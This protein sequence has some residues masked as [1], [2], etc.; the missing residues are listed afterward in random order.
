MSDRLWIFIATACSGLHSI[1]EIE[2]INLINFT[3]ISS[4]GNLLLAKAVRKRSKELA[5]TPPAQS[6]IQQERHVA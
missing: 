2:I 5:D 3:S 4:L 6:Q 1:I